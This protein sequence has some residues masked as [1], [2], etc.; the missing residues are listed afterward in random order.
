[1][2]YFPWKGRLDAI[3]TQI[4]GKGKRVVA[5]N[6]IRRHA[7]HMTDRVARLIDWLIYYTWAYLDRHTWLGACQLGALGRTLL[8][9]L[10]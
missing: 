10:E 1:M 4:Q 8:G 7:L 5:G 6:L 9:V 3:L 2:L